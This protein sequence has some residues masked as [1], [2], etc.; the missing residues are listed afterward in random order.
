[1]RSSD[2]NTNGRTRRRQLKLALGFAALF[3]TTRSVA[4]RRLLAVAIVVTTLL[5]IHGMLAYWL[6]D[7]PY[8]GTTWH[9]YLES[10]A[11]P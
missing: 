6:Q 9:M 7:V 10:F 11:H 2:K 5:A 8:D 1:M 3:E 4:G